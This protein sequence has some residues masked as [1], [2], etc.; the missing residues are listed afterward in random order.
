MNDN[1]ESADALG[2]HI[3]RLT[4]VIH[5]TIFRL[6]GEHTSH[7]ESLQGQHHRHA[8][9]FDFNAV[10][11]AVAKAKRLLKLSP[12][13]YHEA[14]MHDSKTAHDE[15]LAAAAA[16]EFLRPQWKRALEEGL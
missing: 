4:R 3:K 14:Q 6:Q 10:D 12:Q 13:F 11:E 7:W 5:D 8:R 16:I 2:Q 15:M 1:S 9:A